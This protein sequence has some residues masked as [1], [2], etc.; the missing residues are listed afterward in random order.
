MYGVRTA[1]VYPEEEK[2]SDSTILLTVKHIQKDW[3]TYYR[4]KYK[5]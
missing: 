1:T 2:K 3:L 4:T 5:K